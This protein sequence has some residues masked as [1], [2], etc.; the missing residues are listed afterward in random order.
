MWRHLKMKMC[1]LET[2]AD[3]NTK[4]M[5]E[6]VKEASQSLNRMT[7]AIVSTSEKEIKSKDRVDITLE[8]YL[9]MRHELDHLR[10]RVD[11]AEEMFAKM[12][13][14]RDL[15]DRIDPNTVN[16]EYSDSIVP[17][18]FTQRVMVTFKIHTC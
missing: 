10:A 18:D 1:Q 9:S 8:E 3:R 4:A 16:V 12:G 5:G 13:I 17:L 11:L 14:Q 7:D 2:S 6:A 15:F